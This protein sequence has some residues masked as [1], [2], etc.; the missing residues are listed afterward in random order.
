M[1]YSDAQA[2]P[3]ECQPGEPTKAFAAFCAYRDLPP[4]VRSI[5][6]AWEAA[7]GQKAHRT[8]TGPRA[9]RQWHA[10]SAKHA[11]VARAAAWDREQDRVARARMAKASIEAKQRRL[12]EAQWLHVTGVNKLR[13]L[14]AAGETIPA[15]VA[16]RMVEV[17]QNAERLEAGDATQRAEVSGPD[18][19]PLVVTVA[20][21]G[22]MVRHAK[23]GADGQPE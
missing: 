11:W 6:S 4:D 17:G 12:T 13:E 20:Q 15:A 14:A 16:L 10:W 22:A 19:A 3:W 9:P 8:R 5:S 1:P 23:P 18:G 7:S 21:L 2:E